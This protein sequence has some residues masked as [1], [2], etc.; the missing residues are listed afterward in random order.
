M[1]GIPTDTRTLV[2]MSA[3]RREAREQEKVEGKVLLDMFTER[4]NK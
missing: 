1:L 2:I 4:S 3:G